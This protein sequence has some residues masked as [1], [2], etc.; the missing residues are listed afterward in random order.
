MEQD[1]PKARRP[2]EDQGRANPLRNGYAK[3]GSGGATAGRGTREGE[4][5]AGVVCLC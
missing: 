5:V 4:R 1:A 2:G 3:T